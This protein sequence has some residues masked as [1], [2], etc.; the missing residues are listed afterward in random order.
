MLLLYLNLVLVEFRLTG[1]DV[2]LATRSLTGS[3]LLDSLE[4]FG[5]CGMMC[6]MLRLL[7]HS[8]NLSIVISVMVSGSIFFLSA[9]YAHTAPNRHE[10]LWSQLLSVKNG[11]NDPWVLLGDFN[12]I[13]QSSE[14]I[15]GSTNRSGF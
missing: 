9:L 13:A 1:L 8:I 12:A 3:K 5:F 14:R 11:M 6:G 15:G 4:E 7:I 2:R 10:L